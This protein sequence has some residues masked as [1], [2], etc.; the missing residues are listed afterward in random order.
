M[1]L[2]IYAEGLVKQFGKT[3]A[4]RS[5][6]LAVPAGQVVGVLG[7]NGAGKTTLIRILSTLLPPDAGQAYVCGHDVVADPV[8]VRRKI[9]LTGQYA[10]VDADLSGTENLVLV[11]RLRGLSRRQARARAAQ[12][13]DRFGL[14]EVAGRPSRTYSGGTRR[15]LDLAASLAGHPQVLCLDEPTTG[16]DPHARREVWRE[17]RELVADG[18]TVVLTTQYLEEADQLADL[19]TVIDRGRVVADGTAAELKR[20]VGGHTLQIRPPTPADLDKVAAI[21]GRRTGF[22]PVEDPATGLLTAPVT[23]PVLVSAVVRDLDDAGITADELALR[24]PSLDE[25]FLALTGQS[26]TAGRPS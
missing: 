1:S 11:A 10:S 9:G 12:L 19:I 20:R 21:L 3:T 8:L 2:G 24:L 17:V 4:L 5:V 14:T 16:L 26:A 13:L 7:P 23:D 18:V 22:S 25:V 6:D 15:R